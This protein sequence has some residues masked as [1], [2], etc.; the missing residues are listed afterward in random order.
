[1]TEH[2]LSWWG[3]CLWCVVYALIC[4]PVCDLSGISSL[5]KLVVCCAGDGDSC[6]VP[7]DV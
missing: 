6:F 4:A 1:M 7:G 5:A 3:R 2:T